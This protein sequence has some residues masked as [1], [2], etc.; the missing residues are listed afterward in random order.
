MNILKLKCIII[1]GHQFISW[2]WNTQNPHINNKT[3]ITFLKFL[4]M[5]L[6]HGVLYAMY[7][8][9]IYAMHL[10]SQDKSIAT[11]LGSQT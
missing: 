3:P 2:F 6:M 9:V 8:G 7:V 4:Q 1:S 5:H 11:A 10:L